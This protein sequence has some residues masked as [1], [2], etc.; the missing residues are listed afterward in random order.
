M[1]KRYH[2]HHHP[3]L[4]LVTM[5]VLYG[6]IFT[7]C[8]KTDDEPIYDFDF[9]YEFQRVSTLPLLNIQY[10]LSQVSQ[11]YP[12]AGLLLSN[13]QY[14][15]DVYKVTYPTYY[16]D[17][18]ITAS[19]LICIPLA[20]EKFP[21]ISFQNGTKTANATAPSEN[22]S[23][24]DYLMVEAIAGNGYIITIP[25]YIGYGSSSDI[26]HPYYNKES[27]NRAVINMIKA[28]NEL[29]GIE[30]ITADTNGHFYLMGYSQGG[31]ATL[32]VLDEIE[33]GTYPG[34]EIIAA[35]CGAGAYDLHS[36]TEYMLDQTTIPSALYLPYFIYAHKAYG[37]I[38]DD[39]DK[40]FN[41]PYASRIPS[42]FDGSKTDAEV[43]AQLTNVVVDLFTSG[44]IDN[45]SVGVDFAELRSVIQENSIQAWNTASSINF[46]HGTA[47]LHV[48]PSQSSD[49]Y[50][51]FIGLGVSTEQV[52]LY[53]FGGLTHSTGIIP[54][55]V[56]TVLWFN[57]L[58][59]K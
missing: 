10:I 55:G 3:I 20:D 53:E 11:Q 17:S 43:E 35:S 38:Q 28:C 47:D 48:P 15:V 54:W 6:L 49:I 37:T 26:V 16:K 50:D 8:K 42:L 30:T 13:T 36:M 22:P 21:V 14:S 1:I 32:S 27:T 33:N 4:V 34:F 5:I 39:L 44:I 2:F 31:G 23:Y 12:D 29:L 24:D 40:F 51:D 52:K 57:E 18:L 45:Y 56:E 59:A 46:Y 19:G 7:S 58:E 25:D 41:E 9:L